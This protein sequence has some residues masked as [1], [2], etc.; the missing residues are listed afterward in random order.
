MPPPRI[1]P[2]TSASSA[3]RLAASASA[4]CTD[5]TSLLA[6]RATAVVRARRR[7]RRRLE[8]LQRRMSAESQMSVVLMSRVDEV[9]RQFAFRVASMR[10]GRPSRP[11]A[12]DRLMVLNPCARWLPRGRPDQ[13]PSGVFFSARRRRR[14]SPRA[15]PI[16]AARASRSALVFL[17]V[18]RV[19]LSS[20]GRTRGSASH[21]SS[22]CDSSRLRARA[23]PTTR[24][25]S[26]SR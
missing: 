17:S 15:G 24:R 5:T 1:A 4:G 7:A 10:S 21:G 18:L 11:G 12:R 9:P 20:R 3:Q 19:V 6:G 14:R 23:R 26:C 8:M 2:M 22:P 16:S 25:A 13:V